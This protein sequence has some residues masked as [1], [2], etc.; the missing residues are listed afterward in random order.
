[1]PAEDAPAK[2]VIDVHRKFERHITHMGCLNFRATLIATMP[3]FNEYCVNAIKHNA[4]TK[5]GEYPSRKLVIDPKSRVTTVDVT[6]VEHAITPA[7]KSRTM[8][9]L[10]R[11]SDEE[12]ASVAASRTAACAPNRSIVRKMKVSETDMWPL[13]LGMG[14][15]IREP[16]ITVI[17][18]KT[19]SRRS[20]C[21][22]GSE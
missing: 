7:L 11:C 20:S 16:M 19:T 15:V 12:N 21:A 9:L 13:A 18:T 2:Y 3:E 17:S 4:T 6:K 8:G 14:M 10:V 5:F 1:M 22:R